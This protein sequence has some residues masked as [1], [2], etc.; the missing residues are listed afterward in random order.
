MKYRMPEVGRLVE[1][2]SMFE[3]DK[4]VAVVIS[5]PTDEEI[6][7]MWSSISPE[8]VRSPEIYFE[9]LTMDGE[10]DHWNEWEWNYI[11]S[12]DGTQAKQL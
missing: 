2:H 12:E 7:K 4:V 3:E 11:D 10:I 8:S 6:D 5:V 9:V 1:Y